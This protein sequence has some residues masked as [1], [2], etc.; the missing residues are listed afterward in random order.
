ML[1]R[2]SKNIGARRTAHQFTLDI[3]MGMAGKSPMMKDNT[4][5]NSVRDL[6]SLNDN[7]GN[8]I[9]EF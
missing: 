5:W 4:Y 9:L 1:I 8:F 2:Q 3:N 7:F 6:R